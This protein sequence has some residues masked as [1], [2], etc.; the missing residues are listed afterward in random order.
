[1]RQS[2][3]RILTAALQALA[4]DLLLVALVYLLF[5]REAAG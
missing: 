4:T 5:L 2:T 3:R 1:V